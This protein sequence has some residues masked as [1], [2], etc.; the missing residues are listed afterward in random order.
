M[1]QISEE[2]QLPPIP[3]ISDEYYRK[4][5]VIE[6]KYTV[7]KCQ[8]CQAKYSRTFNTGDFTFK[9]VTDEECEKCHEKKILVIEEIYSEFYDTKKDKVV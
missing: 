9:K 3:S 5:R 1:F 6:R 2:P 4:D 7:L 8:S